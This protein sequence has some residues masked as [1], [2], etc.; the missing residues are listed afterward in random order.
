VILALIIAQASPAP[1]AASPSPAVTAAPSPPPPVPSAAPSPT[2]A[3]TPIAFTY[4]VDLPAAPAGPGIRQVAITQQT[5]HAGGP[6]AMRVTTTPDITGVTVEGY[7]AHFALFAVGEIGSGVF[8]AM[9]TVPDAPPQ[10]LDRFYT[11][12]VV[13]T[14][15]DGRHANASISVRL[16]R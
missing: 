15:A 6:W 7:G 2:P 16:V 12:T 11:V 8:A 13:G 5:L 14:T 1:P 9:G 10:Y 4:V 3:A